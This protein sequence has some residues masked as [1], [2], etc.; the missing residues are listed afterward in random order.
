M[1]TLPVRHMDSSACG[2][3]DVFVLG[4][5]LVFSFVRVCVSVS[6]ESF[7]NQSAIALLSLPSLPGF[8]HLRLIF[9]KSSEILKNFRE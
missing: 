7:V 3:F 2:T 9:V 6:P 4:S 5:P 1:K 8:L